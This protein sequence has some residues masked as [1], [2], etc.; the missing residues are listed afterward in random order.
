M[1]NYVTCPCGT[2][3]LCSSTKGV[4]RVF[5]KNCRRWVRVVNG[6]AVGYA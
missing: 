2:A 3:I 4:T 5:C 1:S 6:S